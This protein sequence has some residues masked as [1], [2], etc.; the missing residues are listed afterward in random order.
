MTTQT[1]T[2]W[3][4]ITTP[5]QRRIQIHSRSTGKAADVRRR[6]NPS[7]GHLALP[8]CPSAPF[9][10]AR[11]VT[12]TLYLVETANCIVSSVGKFSWKQSCTF[13]KHRAWRCVKQLLS[14]YLPG[15]A[16][17]VPKKAPCF[18]RRRTYGTSL[19]KFVKSI[20]T[21]RTMK[22]CPRTLHVASGTWSFHFGST[23][24][25]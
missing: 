16:Y 25:Q 15:K 24:G 7:L 3:S 19:R 11:D 20:R 5:R 18:K 14:P 22:L 1:T 6:R 17:F 8:W 10:E 9:F 21:I 23:P 4:R 13:C 12:Q 2:S